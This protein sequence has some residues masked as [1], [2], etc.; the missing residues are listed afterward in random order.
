[1]KKATMT[2]IVDYLTNNLSYADE[3]EKEFL[4]STID[5][6][7]AELNKGK[8]KADANKAAYAAMH[9]PVMEAIRIADKAVTAADI[10]T[11]TGLSRSKVSYGLNNYWNDEIIIDDSG[12]VKTYALREGE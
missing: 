1:M 3:S 4:Q 7:T 6:L 5:E 11:E 2:A 10:A 12:K 8:A 9:D